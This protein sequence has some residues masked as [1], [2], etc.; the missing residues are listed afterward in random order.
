MC[1]LKKYF[2]FSLPSSLLLSF[3]SLSFLLNL[4]FLSCF[5]S[6]FLSFALSFLLIYFFLSVDYLC[7]LRLSVSATGVNFSSSFHLVSPF[8]GVQFLFSSF[9]LLLLC[10]YF[11]LFRPFLH[12]LCFNF[13]LFFCLCLL[14]LVS[15]FFYLAVSSLIFFSIL[16][17]SYFVL[18]VFTIIIIY[19]TLV[20]Y[21]GFFIL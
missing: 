18:L 8:F 16:R 1:Y 14:D 5:F 15:L 21:F 4:S 9:L 10:L 20:H 2:D 6:H 7:C 12:S 3:F 17:V 19:K 13:P 11:L